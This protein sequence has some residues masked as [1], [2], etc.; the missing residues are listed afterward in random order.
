HGLESDGLG[1]MH[2]EPID[3]APHDL[4][5]R[6]DALVFAAH[7]DRTHPPLDAGAMH[8]VEGD[9]F[10]SLAA[11]HHRAV[12]GVANRVAPDGGIQEGHAD[13]DHAVATVALSERLAEDLIELVDLVEPRGIRTVENVARS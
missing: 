8:D 13:A 11:P 3:A 1:P 12:C 9:D 10:A 4:L 5:P 6:S 2:L 7:G